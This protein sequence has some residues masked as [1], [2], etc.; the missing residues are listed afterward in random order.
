MASDLQLHPNLHFDVTHVG[1]PLP[2]G[3]RRLTTREAALVLGVQ[4][5]ALDVWRC[6]KRY[7]LPYYRVGRRIFYK[8]SDV[9]SFMEQCRQES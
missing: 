6:V 9:M 1:V 3:D 5:H 2:D 4:P 7:S 8:L